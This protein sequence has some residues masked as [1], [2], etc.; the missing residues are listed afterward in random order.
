MTTPASSPKMRSQ[1]MTVCRR[2]AMMNSVLPRNAVRMA[3]CTARSVSASTEAVAD[4]T[5]GA[6][7]EHNHNNPTENEQQPIYEP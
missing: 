4:E 3:V 6:Q 2:C 7:L 5:E 1:S